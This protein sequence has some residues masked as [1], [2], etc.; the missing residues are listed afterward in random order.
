MKVWIDQELCTGDGLCVEICP[1]V[2]ALLDDGLSYVKQGDT[3]LNQPGGSLQMATVGPALEEA[4]A[5]AAGE[6]PAEC[7]VME[8][9]L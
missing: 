3:V 5:E 6:C 9:E 2:F 4:V 7:I 1:E 8:A